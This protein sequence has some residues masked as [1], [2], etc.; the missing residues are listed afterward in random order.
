MKWTLAVLTSA[1]MLAACQAPE[2]TEPRPESATTNGVL[3]RLAPETEA[4]CQLT[5]GWDPWEPYHFST[6]GDEVQ[7]LDIELVT[8]LADQVGCE[9]AFIQ[10]NW[11]SLLSLIRVGELDLLPGATHTPEREEF[12]WFSAPYREETFLLYVRVDEARDWEADSLQS[13]LDQ[14]F[15]LGVTQ[16]YIYGDPINELQMDEQYSDNFVEAAVA[17]L[18]FANL[19]DHTIDGFVEDPFVAAAIDRRR[20]W[21]LDIEPLA[22]EFG[23]GQV[24]L[25]F[26]RESV[27]EELVHEFDQALRTIRADGTY[28]RIMGR[29]RR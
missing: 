18:N 15:R 26:S 6:A 13:L 25:L 22:L 20:N 10:G 14:E 24:H 17:E 4:P 19:M 1:F 23:Y 9:L 16:G 5:M 29:Y 3:E 12:S 21:G 7:G 8:A 11:A 2:D 28:D 27:D